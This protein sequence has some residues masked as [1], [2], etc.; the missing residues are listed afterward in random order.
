[1]VRKDYN[2]V[3]YRTQ[4]GKFKAIV[5]DV[6]EHHK[7]GQ[8]VLV[9]TTSVEKSEI[10]SDMLSKEGIKHEVLNAKYHE[11]EAKIVAQ[12]G[13]K[14]AVTIATN[15][16]GRGTDIALGQGVRELGGL[17]IIGSERHESRRIDNQLRGRSG[18]QGDPGE[19]VFYVSFEDDLMR[20][21]GGDRMQMIM[22]SV[23]LDDN[24]PISMG[25]LGRTIENAQKK[26]ESHNYDI[27][28]HLVE[29]DDVLNQQRNIIY[30]LRTKVLEISK[31]PYVESKVDLEKD[32]K[33][34]LSID[35]D[36]LQDELDSFSL[37]RNETWDISLLND[38]KFKLT[39]LDIFVL[40]KI[41]EHIDFLISSQLEDDMKI[42]NIEERNL[43][44]QI[45][46]L[47]TDE[48]FEKATKRLKFKDSV[49]YFRDLYGKD[50]AQRGSQLKK[51]AL[52]AFIEH[53]YGI[54][55]LP[56][57]ELSKVLILQSIDR[58]WMEHLDNMQDLRE[59]I[60]LRNLAQ[61]DPLVEYKNE[62]F[63]LFDS[64]LGS[65][66][67]DLVNRFFKVR[68]VKR[69]DQL[70]APIRV[71]KEQVKSLND[72]RPGKVD[73]QQTVKRTQK[74]VGRNDPCPC[75]S[76]K[77]YKKCCYPKYG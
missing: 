51:L 66:D 12:A 9:G 61:R 53:I 43:Y 23:G 21:F 56:M 55:T 60:S 40:K 36:R 45:K 69:E 63:R 25:I 32:I 27:R 17:Y 62:G 46:N 20:L 37:T 67:N 24:T 71:Q 10:L 19:S 14:G 29:Y 73:K 74:K 15:M 52:V 39:P 68:V 47:I 28:K 44:I 54:G 3:V 22:A 58:Y 64:M 76:G 34:V 48:I 11:K 33:Y 6:K 5:E 72:N 16:A 38:L 31:Q 77:K 18:R 30:D 2:D 59:G 49:E 8:P 4:M 7:K 35:I 70:R 65:I 13:Q 42:D 1:M 50:S 41:L 26:V 57:R 75:G